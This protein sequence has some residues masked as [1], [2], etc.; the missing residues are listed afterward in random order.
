[1]QVLLKGKIRGV[2]FAG[3]PQNIENEENDKHAD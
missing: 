3:W 2:G 1:M